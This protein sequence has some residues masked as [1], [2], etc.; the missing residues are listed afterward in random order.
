M[1][2]KLHVP[3]KQSFQNQQLLNLVDDKTL[4][5]T[6]SLYT[7]YQ[8]VISYIVGIMDDYVTYAAHQISRI[9]Y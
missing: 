7:K 2:Y 3:D 5:Q 9:R 1:A 4:K 8:K 6:D